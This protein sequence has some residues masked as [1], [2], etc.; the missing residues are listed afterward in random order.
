[1][2]A[3]HVCSWCPARSREDV[4]CPETGFIDGCQ[5]LRGFWD[6]NLG[7]FKGQQ[8]LPAAEPMSLNPLRHVFTPTFTTS[9]NWFLGL[10][11]I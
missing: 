7:L 9:C 10:E 8:V 11:T 2:Y 5:P 4:G 1:M 3:Q 6:P